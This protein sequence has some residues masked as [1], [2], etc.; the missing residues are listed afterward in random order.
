[1]FE[2]ASKKRCRKEDDSLFS[3]QKRS[4]TSKLSNIKFDDDVP[5]EQK[6]K[7]VYEGIFCDQ[8]VPDTCTDSYIGASMTCRAAPG[9]DEIECNSNDEYMA[10]SCTPSFLGKSRYVRKVDYLIDEV[11][12]KSRMKYNHNTSLE[13]Q[14]D[15]SIPSSIGPH[16]MTDRL[17][18][19]SPQNQL[20]PI[21]CEL[22]DTRLR[23]NEVMACRA[24]SRYV[25]T[26]GSF[27]NL[28]HN[29]CRLHSGLTHSGFK[30]HSDWLIEEVHDEYGIGNGSIDELQV[31]HNISSMSEPPAMSLAPMR[32]HKPCSD[33]GE[34]LL[35]SHPKG[36]HGYHTLRSSQDESRHRCDHKFGTG[37]PVRLGC[38]TPYE[39]LDPISLMSSRLKLI[40]GID[41]RDTLRCRGPI[42]SAHGIDT[43][44]WQSVFSCEGGS[45]QS[46]QLLGQTVPVSIAEYCTHDG[47][48][49]DEENRENWRYP[50]YS[51]VAV[52][53]EGQMSSYYC[54]G[55]R[56][57][58][59]FKD[60]YRAGGLSV[61]ESEESGNVGDGI[62]IYPV[63][64]A[65]L[66][67]QDACEEGYR[68]IRT[69]SVW[70]SCNDRL[71]TT[72]TGGR[73]DGNEHADDDSSDDDLGIIIE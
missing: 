51:D 33:D 64:G 69:Y 9:D 65:D 23:H 31:H 2:F 48:T 7:D 16:P 25:P 15:F 10:P 72:A 32:K 52:E 29:P 59:G 39:P 19:A 56:Y 27:P 70:E 28:D 62:G 1:M 4:I 50:N 67:E 24:Q 8:Q 73:K 53:E 13:S 22:G 40:N 42:S 3:A 14:V 30:T 54:L 18:L 38:A 71:H 20:I 55:N 35:Q 63:C 12:R 57:E 68:D 43:A 45:G 11:I 37:T 58:E 6:E 49:G 47:V 26:R 36:Y 41:Q 60:D 66:M 17:L 44:A 61:E 34:G 46:P 5:N 21:T